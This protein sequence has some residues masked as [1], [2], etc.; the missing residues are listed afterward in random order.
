MLAREPRTA[1]GKREKKGEKGGNDNVSHVSSRITVTL[2]E[3][4][5]CALSSMN[6]PPCR[7]LRQLPA[8]VPATAAM[9]NVTAVKSQK[10]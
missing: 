10:E 1:K 5:A 7:P 2:T 4:I 9:I 6:V 3:N 8:S